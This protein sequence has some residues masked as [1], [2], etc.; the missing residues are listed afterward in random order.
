[1]AL[2]EIHPNNCG[3]VAIFQAKLAKNNQEIQQK[4]QEKDTLQQ[5]LSGAENSSTDKTPLETR[6][7]ALNAQLSSLINLGKTYEQEIEQNAAAEA[8]K[9]K[10]ETVPE[11]INKDQRINE[12]TEKLKNI[13]KEQIATESINENPYDKDGKDIYGLTNEDYELLCSCNPNLDKDIIKAFGAR[14]AYYTNRSLN[15]LPEEMEA[16]GFKKHGTQAEAEMIA[17]NPYNANG[18]D[19]FGKTEDDYYK[20]LEEYGY[21]REIVDATKLGAR[22]VYFAHIQNMANEG[23]PVT[24]LQEVKNTEETQIEKVEEETKPA[25]TEKPDLN[26]AVIKEYKKEYQ[27]I[28]AELEKYKD[29]RPWEPEY[30]KYRHLLNK[31]ET[32]HNYWAGLYPNEVNSVEQEK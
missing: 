22:R 6:L 9:Q 5:E 12:L 25:Q 17:E 20:M 1:M 27:K 16:T 11:I 28:Q 15:D 26:Q 13:T 14:A 30:K 23:L 7:N 4:Q 2:Q 18:K 32:L 3:Q 21:T 29:V 8:R 31:K 24:P 10:T 19:K